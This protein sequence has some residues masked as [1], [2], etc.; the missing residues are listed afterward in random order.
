MTDIPPQQ[1][2]RHF[3]E[4]LQVRDLDAARALLAPGFT[5]TFPGGVTM[6]KLEELVAWAALRY[7]QIAKTFDGF[8]DLGNVVYCHGTLS[9]T[10][11]DGTSFDGVRFVD[12]FEVS[13]GKL[14]RQDV[15]NDLAEAR[16]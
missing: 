8:D 2:V 13:E 9:G 1:L 6:T 3:L 10:W 15:W 16:P 5:M 12:R 14:T 7:R 11:P 4:T